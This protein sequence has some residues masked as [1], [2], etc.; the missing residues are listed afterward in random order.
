MHRFVLAAGMAVV[1]LLTG[2]DREPAGAKTSVAMQPV[3]HVAWLSRQ[4][5]ESTIGYVRLPLLWDTW[6]R[7]GGTALTNVQSL[8]A[9]QQQIEAIRTALNANI[10][11][12]LPGTLQAP[13]SLLFDRIDTPLEFALLLPPDGSLVPNVLMGT[14][15]ELAPD[16]PFAPLLENL[17]ASSEQLRILT[18]LDADGY[19]TLFAGPMPLYLH[20]ESASSRLRVLSGASAT[21]AFL[22]AQVGAKATDHPVSAL[23]RELDASGRGA[24]AWL[25]V[26]T[27]WPMASSYLEE[28][29][30]SALAAAGA[31]QLGSI[32][33]GSVARDGRSQ[34]RLRIE[35]PPDAGFRRLLPAP[36]S[37]SDVEARGTPDLVMRL[38][39]PTRA[40]LASATEYVMALTPEAAAARADIDE[41]L[42]EFRQWFGVEAGLILDACGSEILIVS[43]EA[44]L[45]AAY[46]MG[47]R[48]A[49]EQVT[50][51]LIS[52]T[53]TQPQAR[54]IGSTTYYSWSLPSLFA[55]SDEWNEQAA[56]DAIPPL[57]R[58]ILER[59][60][61][62]VYWVDEGNYQVSASVPQ[63]L[64]ARQNGEHRVNV[65]DW[66]QSTFGIDSSH[67]VA[68][69]AMRSDE[70]AR[71]VY[72]YYLSTLRFFADLSGAQI[73]PYALPAWDDAGL[74]AGGGVALGIESGPQALSLH[75]NYQ[76]TPMEMLLGTDT[77]AGVA[78]LGILAAIAVPAY[79]DYLGRAQVAQAMLA[80]TEAK[81]AVAESWFGSERYPDFA[82]VEP[83]MQAT[84]GWNLGYDAD[85]GAITVYFE[86]SAA[87]GIAEGYITLIP[88]T[89]EESMQWQCES[90]LA[91]KFLPAECRQYE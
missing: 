79:Q 8:P 55:L 59:L 90:D 87:S 58:D 67:S 22:T 32:W 62:H 14:V 41:V 80:T 86:S 74:P 43:D 35:M 6:F 83:M 3:P 48:Q 63:V 10:W 34:L 13:L 53:G 11:Q 29:Q 1:I 5:P 70:G 72:H 21:Q 24:S 91:A 68:L 64:M 4:L 66:L 57:A 27:L 71:N 82:A 28:S 25:D 60:G 16:E 9:H 54:E 23:E 52:K 84:E 81:L 2:C 7:P 19:A 17:V 69:L 39:L 46:E 61:S 18:P 78:I 33:M 30:R 36:N 45:W 89:G 85:S 56:I 49:A 20:F 26:A 12:Q 51:A 73:D 88:V 37:D 15:L 38:S 47:D 42:E 50:A 65:G 77:L 40:E 76:Y 75:L 44:G 31:D